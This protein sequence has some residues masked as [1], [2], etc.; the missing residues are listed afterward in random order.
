[1]DVCGICQTHLTGL[2]TEM[3][4]GWL[5]DNSGMEDIYRHGVGLPLSPRAKASLMSYEAVSERILKA[6]LYT[7]QAKI[8]ITVAHAPTE[9]AEDDA[10]DAFYETLQNIT[11]DVLTS[12]TLIQTLVVTSDPAKE[13]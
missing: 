5:S 6:R 3:I 12:V 13:Y 2:S 8:S 7:K 11:D 9:D 1:M 4:E 10:K